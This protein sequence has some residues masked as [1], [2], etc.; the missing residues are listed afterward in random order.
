ML[1]FTCGWAI[2]K[3]ISN[4]MFTLHVLK[5]SVQEF[6]LILHH[7]YQVMKATRH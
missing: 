4:A 7:Q 5:D 2:C 1:G 6:D 3:G